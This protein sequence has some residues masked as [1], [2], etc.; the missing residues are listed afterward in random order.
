MMKVLHVITTIEAGG[1][2]KQLVVLVRSQISNGDS[3]KVLYLKGWNELT[4][5]LEASGCEVKHAPGFWRSIIAI[6]REIK[7]FSPEITHAHLP[8]AEIAVALASIWTRTPFVISRHNSES[9]WPKVPSWLS[10]LTSKLVT[11]KAR[12]IIAISNGVKRFIVEKDEICE[13]SKIEVVYYGYNELSR[14]QEPKTIKVSTNLNFLSVSRLTRQK[15]IPTLLDA[16]ALHLEENSHSLL[17]IV[18]DG[19]LRTQLKNYSGDLGIFDSV[20]WVGKTSRIEGFYESHDCLVLSS[21]YEGFGLVLLEAMQF[22]L[23]ILATSH[24]VILEVLSASHPG[25]FQI[26]DRNKL[27]SLMNKLVI[28]TVYEQNSTFTADRL[29]YFNPAIQAMRIRDCYQKERDA[30]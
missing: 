30:L 11:V 20:N 8:Q 3:V 18:G 1:A 25:L 24:E 5:E 21:L 23:P 29:K 4:L 27:A 7:E 2:E 13:K 10:K 12:R 19:E 6:R 17:T 16:F 26:G 14:V 22:G 15:D 28:P 9:F